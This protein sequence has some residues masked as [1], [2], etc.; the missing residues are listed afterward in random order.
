MWLPITCIH[1]EM[2]HCNNFFNLS[3][4]FFFLWFYNSSGEFFV[5]L[6][7]MGTLVHGSAVPI[8]W[9]KEF[10]PCNQHLLTSHLFLKQIFDNVFALSGYDTKKSG[11][12]NATYDCVLCGKVTEMLRFKRPT[13]TLDFVL[14]IDQRGRNAGARYCHLHSFRKI[15]A[16]TV[17]DANPNVLVI[18]SGFDFD[19]YLGMLKNQPVNVSFEEKLVFE[20]HWYSFAAS[21]GWINCNPNDVCASQVQFLRHHAFFLLDQGYPLF[22]SE[23]GVNL[24]GDDVA[25]NRHSSCVFALL[26]ELDLDWAL[27]TLMG[28]YYYRENVMEMNEYYDVLN[29]D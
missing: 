5:V 19:K 15:G 27:W 23:W 1:V 28:S 11:K 20:V 10:F 9:Y 12:R 26:A 7:V 13:Q 14:S 18:L 22:M 2:P 25:D 3:S 24:K 17:H 4:P 16:E 21:D 8:H 29:W 6:G